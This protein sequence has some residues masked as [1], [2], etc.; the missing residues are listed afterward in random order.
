MLKTEQTDHDLL[1]RVDEKLNI[2]TQT[3]IAH[4]PADC[5][6]HTG[7]LNELTAELERQ[8]KHWEERYR[9]HIV[10]IKQLWEDKAQQADFLALQAKVETHTT[11]PL[12][13]WRETKKLLTVAVCSA[14][15]TGIVTGFIV[16]FVH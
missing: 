2:M 11:E 4:V 15:V 10:E 8:R 16:H 14:L 1:V 9:E 3:V 13:T 6:T 5:I 7:I 12:D